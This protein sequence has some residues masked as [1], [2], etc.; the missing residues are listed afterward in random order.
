[1]TLSRRRV[2]VSIEGM[3]TGM[4]SRLAFAETPPEAGG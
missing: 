1:V 3:G 2:P 4:L